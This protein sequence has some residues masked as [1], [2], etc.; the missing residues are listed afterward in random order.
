MPHMMIDHNNNNVTATATDIN[1]N[2]NVGMDGYDYIRPL[3]PERTTSNTSNVSRLLE[4]YTYGNSSRRNR[5]SNNSAVSPS[6][7]TTHPTSYLSTSPSS[8]PASSTSS[9]L[10][11]SP[12]TIEPPIN[13]PINS[14]NEW[15]IAGKRIQTTLDP[16]ITS[17]PPPS[18]QQQEYR[19]QVT[20]D[21]DTF[22]GLVLNDV[23]DYQQI[24]RAILEKVGLA[25]DIRGY[26]YYHE[27]GNHPD[28]PLS[29]EGLINICKTSDHNITNRIL[30]KPIDMYHGSTPFGDYSRYPPQRPVYEAQTTSHPGT[31]TIIPNQI[32]DTINNNMQIPK[33]STPPLSDHSP[34]EINPKIQGIRLT[35]PPLPTPPSSTDNIPLH[36]TNRRLEGIK[37]EDPPLYSPSTPP[38]LPSSVVD[39]NQMM[40]EQQLRRPAETLWPTNNNINNNTN[41]DYSFIPTSPIHTVNNNNNNNTNNNNNKQIHDHLINNNNNNYNHENSINN[42]TNING[43]HENIN[44]NNNNKAK[45]GMYDDNN[46]WQERPSIEQLYRDIDN[47]LPD[48]DLDKEIEVEKSNNNNNSNN[49]SSS[50]S[51]NNN[52]INPSNNNFSNNNITNNSNISNNNN[53]NN[54][55]SNNMIAE[56]I[57]KSNKRISIRAV[58]SNAH[59]T[60]RQ[61]LDNIQLNQMMRRRSTKLWGHT[62]RQVKPGGAHN[63]TQTTPRVS[64]LAHSSYTVT[65][66]QVVEKRGPTKMQWVRG[67]LIGK[68][69]YGRV[70][71]ALNVEAGEWIAVKQVDIP[72]SKS[73]LKNEKLMDSVEALNQEMKLLADLEHENIV[74]YL[75]YDIDK[76]EDH[77]YIF[78]EYIPGGSLA[79]S[80]KLKGGFDMRLVQFF[81]R[82]ILVGLEYLHEKHILHRDI[83]GGNILVDEDGCCKI[84]DFGLS[85]I[86][87][88]EEAYKS[89]SN[90][91]MRGSIYWM[92][93]EVVIGK[94]YGAKVDIWS[95]G[96]TVIEM[97]TGKHPWED[98]NILAVLY[99]LGKLQAPPIPDDIPDEA[100]EFIQRCLEVE[101]ENR[102]T[103][104]ELL[105]NHPFVRQDPSF[106]F[107]EF[108]KNINIQ[109]NE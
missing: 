75:G 17:S 82:Q 49:N 68:G 45:N 105:S 44:I 19:I 52:N 41:E 8:N 15:K 25:G 77:L 97:F 51:S 7:R 81:T 95:L 2:N 59:Q 28:T 31:T 56:T 107:K 1:N 3:I 92:A 5:G 71:H 101:P 83:K 61:S 102:P 73:D 85:K 93:P 76:E 11:T 36:D 40:D 96:C 57:A 99:N 47:Y 64:P 32:Q 67:R 12:I 33:R 104:S 43:D 88:Q 16:V 54:N 4:S 30:V 38:S 91:S 50:S 6:S 106:N 74:Q 58:A 80:L 60:W 37:L 98:L 18:Q 86:S 63:Q 90:N 13:P 108:V 72:S 70:Y 20:T 69:S 23:V 65:H 39:T 78:L 84:T 27:N 29:N 94:P 89:N 109:K 42:H 53:N 9:S 22:F 46:V 21:S 35:D 62:V 10:Q 100:K 79:S 87:N 66:E 55:N 26:S 14:N 24:M 48:H 34:S 103:A